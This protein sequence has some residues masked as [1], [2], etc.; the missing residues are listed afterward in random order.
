MKV[1]APAERKLPVSVK[2]FISI[3][4]PYGAPS[5]PSIRKTTEK[6][7]GKVNFEVLNLWENPALAH[8]YGPTP[9]TAVNDRW[10]WAGA[11]EYIHTLEA[12]REEL[13]RLEKS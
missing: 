6:F 4:C 12:I 7:G 2:V 3:P 8:R 11:G 9:G 13:K 1:K 10:I 5:F